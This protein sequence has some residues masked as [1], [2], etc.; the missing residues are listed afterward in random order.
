MNNR[1][2]TRALIAATATA[3]L[4]FQSLITTAHAEDAQTVEAYLANLVGQVA[5]AEEEVATAESEIAGLRESANKARVDLDVAQSTAQAAQDDVVAARNTLEQADT[6]VASAQSTLDDIAR[7]AYANRGD[8]TAIHLAAGGTDAVSDTLDRN[9]ILLQAASKQQ[10]EV[11]R[12]DLARTQIANKEAKL[13]DNR[14]QADSALQQALNAYEQ[15]ATAVEQASANL[16]SLESRLANLVTN[17]EQAEARLRAARTAVDALSN[18]NPQATSFQKRAAAEAAVNQ[19]NREIGQIDA[20]LAAANPTGETTPTVSN[21]QAQQSGPAAP[22]TTGAVASP[23]SEPTVPSGTTTPAPA[24]PGVTNYSGDTTGEVADTQTSSNTAA[25]S[26]AD[27]QLDVPSIA[28][29]FAGSAE[30]DSQRQAAID[31][32]VR[33]GEAAFMAGFT[34]YASG[35]QDGAAQAAIEA[36]TRVAGEQYDA[37]QAALAG[38]TA[39]TTNPTA[40]APNTT[41]PN[42]TAPVTTSPTTTAPETTSPAATDPAAGT[43]SGTGTTALPPAD[44]TVD[45]TGDAAAKIERVIARAMSQLG[46]TYAWGG[47]NHNGPTL[48]IRDGGV[49]DRHGDYAKVGFDCSGLMMYAFNAVGI[50]LQHYSGYQYTA[51]KQVPVAQAK[52]GDMLFW[53]PGGSQHVALYLGDNQMIEAPQSGSV[54]KI[55]PV[56]WGNIQPMAVRLIE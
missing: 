32:L 16:S 55:S 21:P 47:G 22:T 8:N 24:L 34:A 25:G 6:E 36:G 53:G 9:S 41:A 45:T 12:L 17:R 35:N 26:L 39:T 5:D 30:G 48:G 19:A 56:R 13:R 33:A 38:N 44:S 10:S 7:A 20:Q 49:A 18:A 11:Q 51:G 14:A 54:V 27:Q 28:T 43:A 3:G 37:A 52:R 2:T 46:V 1:R 4:S 42:T 50:K 23:T 31:G 40:T 29:T 15:A